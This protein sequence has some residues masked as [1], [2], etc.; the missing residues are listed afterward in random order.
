MS[1]TFGK[2]SLVVWG[3]AL[4]IFPSSIFNSISSAERCFDAD[5]KAGNFEDLNQKKCEFLLIILKRVYV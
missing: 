4:L 3:L 5:N 2:V 1:I